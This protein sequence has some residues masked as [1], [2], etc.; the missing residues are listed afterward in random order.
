MFLVVNSP[1]AVKSSNRC[2]IFQQ[3]LL[4]KC[5]WSTQIHPAAT[6]QKL[7]VQHSYVPSIKSQERG[8]EDVI[9]HYF[10]VYL[11]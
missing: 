11:S 5:S 2:Q 4:L 8:T 10:G 6:I 7:A 3:E 1:F 9:H